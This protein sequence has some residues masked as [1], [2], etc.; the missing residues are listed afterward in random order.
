M[1]PPNGSKPNA[2]APNA[3]PASIAKSTGSLSII[4]FP[5]PDAVL[6]TNTAGLIKS[7]NAS[8][9]PLT[10]LGNILNLSPIAN[11][12]PLGSITPASL[13]SAIAFFLAANFLALA[14]SVLAITCLLMALFF[15]N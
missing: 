13:D 11:L 4:E 3:I 5:K 9:Y 14:F 7:S 1:A 12:L 10:S 6:P 8:P 2:P 15:S